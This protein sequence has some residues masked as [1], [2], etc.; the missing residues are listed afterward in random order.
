MLS[1]AY[2][3]VRIWGKALNETEIQEGSLLEGPIPASG[4]LVRHYPMNTGSGFILY[5]Q[6][7]KINGTIYEGVR[8]LEV[9]N[10]YRI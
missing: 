9:S 7:K 5:D 10:N 3:Q 1:F 2:V 6:L 8:W 4:D